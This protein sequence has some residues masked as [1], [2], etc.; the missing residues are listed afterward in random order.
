MLKTKIKLLVSF[1]IVFGLFFSPILTTSAEDGSQLSGPILINEVQTGSLVPVGGDL[2]CNDTC[3]RN[4]EF[5]ELVNVG[6]DSVDISGWQLEYV[7]TSGNKS[8]IYTFPTLSTLEAAGLVVGICL[9]APPEYLSEITPKI[10]YSTCLAASDAG[11]NLL[12]NLGVVIDSVSWTSSSTST[13]VNKVLNLAAGLSMERLIAGDVI[14]D[15]DT[16]AD[17][18]VGTPTPGE[19]AVEIVEPTPEPTP[20]PTPEITPIPEDEDVIVPTPTPDV[21]PTPEPTP[22]PILEP[23]PEPTPT[24]EVLTLELSELYIDPADPLLDSQDEWVEIH[25]PNATAVDLEGYIIYTGASFNYK[26]IFK[27]GQAIEPNSYLI[28]SSAESSLALSN[29]GGAA[30]IVGPDSQVLDQTTYETAKNGLAWAK[31]A[32]GNWQWTATPTANGLNIIT[33]QQVPE[34]IKKA[35]VSAA[36]TKKTTAKTSTTTAKTTKAAKATEVKA[37]TDENI[38]TLVN[39]P[40]P[41]PNWLLALLGTLAVIYCLYEYRFELSNKIYQLRHYKEHRRPNWR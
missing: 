34:V 23:T 37:T 13:A 15:T 22:E 8:I 31:T 36:S 16:K 14:T 35:T 10:S 32:D 6:T 41:L 17:F 39:A 30:K 12:N 4:K 11:L 3:Y 33:A 18:V 29:S 40:S 38:N 19:L 27:T 2:S 1:Y 21:E 20:T 25:N 9:S 7:N 26:H 24:P 28:I 5:I